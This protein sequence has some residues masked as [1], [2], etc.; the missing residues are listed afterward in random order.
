[1]PRQG[2]TVGIHNNGGTYPEFRAI[3]DELAVGA[4]TE[5]MDD[6]RDMPFGSHG[7]LAHSHGVH[8]FFQQAKDDEGRNDERHYHTDLEAPSFAC[9]IRGCCSTLLPRGGKRGRHGCLTLFPRF[10]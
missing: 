6:L 10:G 3:F 5:L 1:M 7:H 8:W 4:D 2:D 9:G